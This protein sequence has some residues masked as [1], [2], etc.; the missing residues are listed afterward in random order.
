MITKIQRAKIYNTLSR[1]QDQLRIEFK[2]KDDTKYWE[3]IKHREALRNFLNNQSFGDKGT[4]LIIEFKKIDTGRFCRSHFS[5]DRLKSLGFEN[6]EIFRLRFE[7]R[8]NAEILS[9]THYI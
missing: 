1:I 4:G 5:N 2:S 8:Y 6:P 3:L 9:I 7:L